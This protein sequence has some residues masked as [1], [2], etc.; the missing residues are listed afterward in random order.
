[1]APYRAPTGHLNADQRPPRREERRLRMANKGLPLASRFAGFVCIQQQGRRGKFANIAST[2]PWDCRTEWPHPGTLKVAASECAIAF[3]TAEQGTNP[4]RS[5]SKQSAVI[6][7]HCWS[8]A[9][10]SR[11][12]LGRLLSLSARITL[13]IRDAGTRVSPTPPRSRTNTLSSSIAWT[14]S[15]ARLSP[16]T[17]LE[18]QK[19]TTHP[20][21]AT[22]Y[23]DRL[24]FKPR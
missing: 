19:A 21:L 6:A 3:P 17:A 10:S 20:P 8:T 18:A 13:S 4:S 12:Q 14:S 16:A 7:S 11:G 22:G 23:G 15:P 1:M 5:Q 2:C 9:T 24:C